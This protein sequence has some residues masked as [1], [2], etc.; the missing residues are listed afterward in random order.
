MMKYVANTSE[1]KMFL[2]CVYLMFDM[3][4]FI[5]YFI[6]SNF[7]SYHIFIQSCASNRL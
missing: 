7:I 4:M 1:N 6:L 3:I 5:K 2:S